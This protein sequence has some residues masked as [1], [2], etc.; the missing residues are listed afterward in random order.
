MTIRYELTRDVTKDECDWLKRDFKQGEIVQLYTGYTYGVINHKVG[1]ACCIDGKTP[2]F[3]L[4][5]T[6]LRRIV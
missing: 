3:E 5:R 6:A 4:P 2:F 1:V